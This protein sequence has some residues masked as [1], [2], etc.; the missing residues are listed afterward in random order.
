MKLLLT[1]WII[2]FIFYLSSLFVIQGESR[3]NLIKINST[4]YSYPSNTF[5]PYFVNIFYADLYQININI[6]VYIYLSIYPS[7]HHDILHECI[8]FWTLSCWQVV[9][10]LILFLCKRSCKTGRVV[11]DSCY[12]VF[13]NWITF[14]NINRLFSL[15][16]FIPWSFPQF[17]TATVT[18]HDTNVIQIDVD[19]H[20]A[21]VTCVLLINI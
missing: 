5:S 16:S 20:D 15:Y 11:G 13:G 6:L 8:L 7:I 14:C 18:V 21:M 1:C 17:P 19:W 12:I 3:R 9:M 4:K 10:L 2:Q